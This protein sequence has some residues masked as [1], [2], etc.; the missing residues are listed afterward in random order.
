M[1]TP[2]TILILVATIIVS[3]SCFGRPELMEKLL[4]NPFRVKHHKEYYRLLSH[5]FVHADYVHLFFNMFTFWSFGTTLESVL[6]SNRI[7]DSSLPVSGT[8]LFAI[9]YFGGGLV[10]TLP[11]MKKHGDNPLYNAVGASG[12]VSAVMLAFMI[13]FPTTT[14]SIFFFPMPAYLG[15]I[16]FIG[17]EHW[18]SRSGK[19][20]IAHDA[21]IYGAMFGLL[22]VAALDMNFLVEFF[23]AVRKS[24]T[25]FLG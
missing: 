9:L 23:A 1:N 12:A 13:M 17:L 20:N 10:A 15:A 22:F 21:H 24:I 19:T 4:F 7:V 16:V 3:I 2:I 25:S 6:S 5:Q 14:I 18:M 8:W 11:S